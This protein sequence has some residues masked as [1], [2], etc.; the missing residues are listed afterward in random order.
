MAVN[1]PSPRI[2]ELLQSVDGSKRRTSRPKTCSSCGIEIPGNGDRK[3]G[4][5]RECWLQTKHKAVYRCQVCGKE[6]QTFRGTR[7][8]DCYIEARRAQ[9]AFCVDCGT[10][11]KQK[12]T[13]RCRP[14]HLQYM[15]SEKMQTRFA[16]ARATGKGGTRTSKAE[17][18]AAALLDLLGLQYERQ[19]PYGRWVIDFHVP[20]L[21][22]YIEVHGGYWH[23]LEK[24]VARDERKMDKL[25]RDGHKVLYW[26][27]DT[28][29]LWMKSMFDLFGLDL[30]SMSGI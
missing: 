13:K 17:E 2:T 22:L 6:L 1:S 29:Y 3:T 9:A 30:P 23:D 11:L 14:C 20:K 25:T 26:R 18:R 8:K 4:M 24:N 19:V 12:T 7:C 28:E 21:N 5:C 16:E 27:T 10:Q 15:T